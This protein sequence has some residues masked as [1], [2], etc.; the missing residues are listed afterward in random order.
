MQRAVE[1]ELQNRSNYVMPAVSLSRLSK[2]RNNA[3]LR[4]FIET[5]GRRTN[6]LVEIVK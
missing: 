3:A 2:T 5:V 6:A 1:R 4:K